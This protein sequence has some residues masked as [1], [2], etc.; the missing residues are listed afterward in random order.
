MRYLMLVG[1]RH[2]LLSGALRMPI[3]PTGFQCQTITGVRDRM[4]LTF[5][6]VI[7]KFVALHLEQ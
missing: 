3:M 1:W 7:M 5:T 2:N 6:N 4:E